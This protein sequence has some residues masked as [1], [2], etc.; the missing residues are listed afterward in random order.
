MH[1]KVFLWWF[2]FYNGDDN[3]L[4]RHSFELK[5][6]Y[7]LEDMISIFSHIILPSANTLQI[8]FKLL[9]KCFLLGLCHNIIKVFYSESNNNVLWYFMCHFYYA[10]KAQTHNIITLASF[11]IIG[12][13]QGR[14]WRKRRQV[15][16]HLKYCHSL[17]IAYSYPLSFLTYYLQASSWYQHM[18][19]WIQMIMSVDILSS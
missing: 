3:I 7:E 17:Y 1:S 13:N 9:V 10:L 14:K 12:F 6:R 11:W 8:T 19:F 15:P 2:S 4:T 16:I 18:Y 5:L